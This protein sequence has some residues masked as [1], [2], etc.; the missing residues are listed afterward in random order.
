MN[1]IK[2]MALMLAIS[3]PASALG[4]AFAGRIQLKS[5]AEVE[6]EV[7]KPNGEVEL[8]RAPAEKVVPGDDVIY[9]ITATNVAGTAVGN[10]VITDP[11]PDHMDYR[12]GSAIGSDTEIAFSVDGG[13]SYGAPEALQVVEDDGTIRSAT[14]QDY[15]HIRW[16]FTRDLPPGESRW[17]RF[18][19]RLQ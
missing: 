17:V 14:A 16:K 11:V 18:R 6:L 10:V 19:A 4:Q 1:A 7:E 8:R 15:T 5:V 13:Q 2:I 3:L 9:T 12:D